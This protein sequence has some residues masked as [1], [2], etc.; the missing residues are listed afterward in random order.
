MDRV[1]THAARELLDGLR[2]DDYPTYAED[3]AYSNGLAEARRRL[4]LA[5]PEIEAEA[6]QLRH[7]PVRSDAWNN[8][9]W[10]CDAPG[11][12]WRSDIDGAFERTSAHAAELEAARALL[13]AVDG[14]R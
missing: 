6:R 10:V 12:D 8:P 4:E 2:P 3:A 11:C 14:Q 5:L 13:A 7:R 9:A 1:E